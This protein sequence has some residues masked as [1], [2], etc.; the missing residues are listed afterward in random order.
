[1]ADKPNFHP[2]QF[3]NRRLW[4]LTTLK[5]LSTRCHPRDRDQKGFRWKRDGKENI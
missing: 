3:A 5:M 4:K 1:M 2:M